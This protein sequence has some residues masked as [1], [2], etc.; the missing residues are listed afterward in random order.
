MQLVIIFMNI[1]INER[2]NKKSEIINLPGNFKFIWKRMS[3]IL[4]KPDQ[5]PPPPNPRVTK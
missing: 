4:L 1:E 3:N 5:K 2:M